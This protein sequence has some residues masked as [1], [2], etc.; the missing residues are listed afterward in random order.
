LD[1]PIVNI[2]LVGLGGWGVVGH[3]RAHADSPHARVVAVCDAVLDRARQVAARWDVPHVLDDYR[4]LLARPDVETVDVA[5]PNDTHREIV[6]AALAAGKHVLCEKPLALTVEHAREMERAAAES[7]RRATVNFV[8]RYA[9]SARYVKLLLDEGALGR[10]YHCNVTYAQGWL[11]DPSFPRVWRLNRSVSGSGV[12]GDL[13]SHAID[14][15]R[16][17]LG[18]EIRAVSGRLTT[19][20]RQR[21]LPPAPNAT[22]SAVRELVDRG[23]AGPSPLVEVDVDDDATWLASF[24]N[25][26]EGHFFTS[27][28]ATA[29]AN[30]IRAE[31]YG[32]DG[33]IVYDNAVADALQASLGRAMW[34][35]NAWA[36]LAVP[37]QLM[38]EDGKNAMHYTV[39]DIVFG[40]SIAP[41]FHDGVRAQEVMDAVVRSAAERRWVDVE[42]SPSATSLHRAAEG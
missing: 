10:I 1:K 18:A 25:G 36:T 15:A 3:M 11:T 35:R 38:R 17:W 13:G 19:F 14:L 37:S 40:T 28:N 39:E 30:H 41:T 21:P 20:T 23:A 6:L 2:G 32:S 31:L 12:L 16:W 33:A 27:R 5:T 42:L 34:R 29:R 22:H 4:A 9:P 8:H 24:D 7:G 26:A